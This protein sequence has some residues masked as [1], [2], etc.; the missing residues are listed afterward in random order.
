M[1]M[2]TKGR[3]GLRVMMELALHH[4]EGP[5]SADVIA[6]NQDLSSQYIHLLTN[7]LRTAGLI[8][9]V[10]GP[11][12]GYVLSR[13]PS[14]IT[15]M[16]IVAALEGDLAPTR[17]VD[18]ASVCARSGRCVA[19]DLWGEVAAA[20]QGVLSGITLDQLAARHRAR[21]GELPDYVI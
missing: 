12:G 13:D 11:S 14:Q 19:R 17:C 5:I 9:A 2:S 18:D 15:A 3:Y 8:R 10:R 6:R 7:G 21:S 16:E 1:Q 4:G 20:I